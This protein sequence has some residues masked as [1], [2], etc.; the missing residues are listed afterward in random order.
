MYS[1]ITISVRFDINAQCDPQNHRGERQCQ[2]SQFQE[3]PQ[4]RSSISTSVESFG[5][6]FLPSPSW[7]FLLIMPKVKL[8]NF[9]E[10]YTPLT[11]FVVLVTK[12]A[13]FSKL[14]L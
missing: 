4:Y 3:T 5:R 12:V 11:D 8:I 14:W 6:Q 1:I 13:R 7:F 9:L 2:C 10:N